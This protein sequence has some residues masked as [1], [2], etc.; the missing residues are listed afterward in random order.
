MSYEQQNEQ[1]ITQ[2]TKCD[3]SSGQLSISRNGRKWY[4]DEKQYQY[5]KYVPHQT[6]KNSNRYDWHNAYLPQL[7][8]IHKIVINTMNERYPKN[9]IKWKTNDQIFNNLSRLMYNCSSNYISEY[10]D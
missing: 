6:P 9:K 8:A 2:R 10:L 5:D 1:S 7:I 4:I 3:N